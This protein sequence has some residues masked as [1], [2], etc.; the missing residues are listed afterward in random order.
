MLFLKMREDQKHVWIKFKA[1]EKLTVPI[2][3]GDI[4]EVSY[5]HIKMKL[6]FESETGENSDLELCTKIVKGKYVNETMEERIVE[7]FN[8]TQSPFFVKCLGVQ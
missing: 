7:K 6:E 5:N 1:D 4:V 3:I 8:V 2:Q